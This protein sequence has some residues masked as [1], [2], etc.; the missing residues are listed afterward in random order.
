[1][2]ILNQRFKQRKSEHFK[3]ALPNSELFQNLIRVAQAYSP[4]VCQL[5][6]LLLKKFAYGFEYQK[7]AIFGFT[8][9]TSDDTWTALKFCD[10]DDEKIN[11]LYQAET[12]NLS[13]APSVGFINYEIDIRGK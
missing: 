13:E 9:K 5:I 4:A 10:P 6:S 12:E 1:M 3:N 7:G 8:K 2:L 11:H